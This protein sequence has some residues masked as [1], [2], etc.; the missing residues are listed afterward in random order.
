MQNTKNDNFI[1]GIAYKL[2]FDIFNLLKKAFASMPV[3]FLL[4]NTNFIS[5][6][7]SKT[8]AYSF[9]GISTYFF[10]Q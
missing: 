6:R 9:A 3:S 7:S 5:D 4:S 1:S 2:I 8:A 10:Y